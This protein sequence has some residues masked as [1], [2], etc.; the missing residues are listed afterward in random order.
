[1]YI[2]IKNDSKRFKP[3]YNQG[4]GR[5]YGSS[6]DYL[7]D[8]KARGLEPY[9][10]KNVKPRER[11]KYVPSRWARDIVREVERSGRV[12]GCVQ[13]ELRKAQVKSVPK[14]LLNKVNSSKGGWF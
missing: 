2:I 13:K 5:Y 6:K 8:I 9:D 14:D 10:P 11:K 12:S 1:M 3:H 4:T 7:A